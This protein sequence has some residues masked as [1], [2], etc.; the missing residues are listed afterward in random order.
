M[1]DFQHLVSEPGLND[2]WEENHDDNE[3]SK[4]AFSSKSSEG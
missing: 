1:V 4:Q 3:S 2:S